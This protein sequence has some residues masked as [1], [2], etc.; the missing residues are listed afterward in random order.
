MS[1]KPH[2]KRN[3]RENLAQISGPSER[4]KSKGKKNIS[5]CCFLGL[6]MRPK[7][8]K[9]WIL[10]IGVCPMSFLS[11]KRVSTQCLYIDKRCIL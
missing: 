4:S 3:S 1:Q 5:V 10:Q 2:A 6:Q 11:L 9:I 8:I 7:T